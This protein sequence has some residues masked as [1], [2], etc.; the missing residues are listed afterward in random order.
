MDGREIQDR[1]AENILMATARPPLLIGPA[2]NGRTMTLD[3]FMDAEEEPGFR[4]ELARGVLEVTQ[5]PNDPH[6][7]IVCNLI[8]A[9]AG[10]DTRHPRAIRRFGEASGFRIWLPGVESG[11]NPDIAVV[12]AGTPRD[13]RGNRPPSLA[14]ELVSEGA[15]CGGGIIR[16]SG[17]NTWPMPPG[18]LDRRPDR[19]SGNSPDPQRR[20]LGRAILR[21]WPVGQRPGPAWLRCPRGRA[22]GQ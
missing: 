12:V 21:R 5:V 13:H 10:Y 11:R 20:C 3:E 17:R 22:V 19:A 16:R 18:I 2:D 4:Y 15:E 6:G 8:R 7:D 14:M 1:P 9:I